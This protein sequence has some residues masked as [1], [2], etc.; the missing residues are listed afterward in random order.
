MKIK[1]NGITRIVFLIG[2]WAIKIP[3]F[4]YQHSH[5]LQGCY[6]N[7][8]E[9]TF[10]RTMKGLPEYFNK[11]APTVFCTWFGLVSVQKRVAELERDLTENETIYF[12]ELTT[13]I[14]KEN[15]GYVNDILVCID[16]V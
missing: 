11:V 12:K 1:F 6:A 15:F 3:N 13:D 4:R 14:K 5:F 16:Y 8:S 7:W 2:K 9:Y 10:C